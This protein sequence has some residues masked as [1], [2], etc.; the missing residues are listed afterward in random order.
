MVDFK[1]RL[2]NKTVESKVEPVE[3][4]DSLDRRS[5]AGPLRESQRAILTEWHQSRRTDKDIIVKLHTGEGKTLIGLLILLSKLNE[6]GE[7]CLFLCPNIYLAT[8][9][10]SEAKKFGIPYCEID[11]DNEIP[12]GFLLGKSILITHVQ[13]LFNGKTKFGLNNKSISAGTVILDDS[14]A[15]IDSIRSSLTIK[16][17]REHKLYESLLAIFEQELRDQGEG[18]YLEIESG[19]YST[20]LP[21]PYWAWS[22]RKDEVI[23]LLMEYK[24]DPEI[25]F[26]W[27]LIKDNLQNCQAFVSGAF[28]EISPILM[29][30]DAFGTFSKANQRILMSATTQD[31]AFA[32]KGLG[33]DVSSIRTPLTNTKLR[34]S[35]EKMILLP[36]L[37]DA[38][39]DRETIVNWLAKPYDSMKF[40]I[41]FLT[42]DFS[43]KSQYERIGSRVADT[44]NIFEYVQK[45]K[46][47]DHSTPIVFA[48]RYDG[49]DLPDDAC[50]IL[51]L[52]SKPYFDSLLDRY[53]EDC[54]VD[55][56][57]INIK[58]AQKVEQGL[59]RSVRGEK[60]Y[61]VIL[62]TGGDL[63][64]FIKSQ[65]SKKYFS[66][67]T[68]KQIDIGIQST[69]FAKEDLETDTP[70]K[71]VLAN[72][73]NQSLRRDADWKEF[74]IEGMNEITET[75]QPEG[76]YDTLNQEY[77]AERQFASGK[78]QRACEIMQGLCDKFNGIPAEKGWYVQQLARY[79]YNISKIESNTI[80]ITAFGLNTQLLKPKTGI[81]YKSINYI[82]ENRHARIKTWLKQFKSNEELQLY[83][84]GLL[85]NLVFGVASEKFEAALKTLGDAL[86]FVSQ[87]P[88][89]EIKKGPDNLWCIG[90]NSYIL[91]EC[92]NE[93]D[94][95]RTEIN[96]HE[97]GQ[98]NTH[99]G[100]F[101]ENYNDAKCKRILIIPPK[102]LSYNGNFTHDVEI[103]RKTELNKL[104]ASFKSFIMEL[105]AS[106][107]DN[108]D[109]DNLHKRIQFHQLDIHS[110]LTAYST[111]YIKSN[112]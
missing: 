77:Q 25:A 40:G 26:V 37:I 71:T 96:K 104:R 46:S 75:A 23:P 15:C 6:S 22:E 84:S 36:S 65:S 83:T 47:G 49:I 21:I 79:K 19:S 60:D 52:D 69:S 58:I 50:R 81:S 13:K 100:W 70:A 72:L 63:T 5:E 73:V 80:Q 92:K 87:R 55:S 107:L 16:V 44:G 111:P 105:Y 2:K 43:K 51:I 76:I 9:V 39:L 7:S 59:G 48:N 102:K 97:A 101:E 32:I 20:M 64:K 67:Q 11:S 66:P 95:N 89:K 112:S 86:G 3:L 54:R 88:D 108:I 68:I 103:M 78:I 10:R 99:C 17:K 29:P 98:M 24:K 93:V 34:W 110:L 94:G 45:L 85:D 27:E 56:D 61:S 57:I 8:Q 31:D 1:K 14:H 12:D 82:N 53:E 62:I 18:S 30:I 33:F 106:D 28:L 91:L 4:Y 42:P 74:Y 41:V 35:G 38:T 109:D 90:T